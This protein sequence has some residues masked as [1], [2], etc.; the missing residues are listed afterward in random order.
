MQ[1]VTLRRRPGGAPESRIVLIQAR[2]TSDIH[3]SSTA[4]CSTSRM[5]RSISS[6]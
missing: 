2:C 5:E 4:I 1:Y 6:Q 3:A